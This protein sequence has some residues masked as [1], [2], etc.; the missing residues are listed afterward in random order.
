M[1]I[2]QDFAF[3]FLVFVITLKIWGEGKNKKDVICCFWVFRFRLQDSA[4][5]LNLFQ[6]RSLRSTLSD[7]L[8][9]CYVI[10]VLQFLNST[11]KRCGFDLLSSYCLWGGGGG[12]CNLQFFVSVSAR[13]CLTA[14]YSFILP[15]TNTAC[16]FTT[17]NNKLNLTALFDNRDQ[18][19]MDVID[20]EFCRLL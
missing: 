15:H 4:F 20:F 1:V 14:S 9:K 8:S 11:L 17:L 7:S 13:P 12:V 19:G 10:V 6:S 3:H 16:T 18:S 2:R 5:T